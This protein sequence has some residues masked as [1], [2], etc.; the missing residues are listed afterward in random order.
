MN[1]LDSPDQTSRSSSEIQTDIQD[2][3]RRMDSTL[4]ELSN[5]LTPRSLMNT[6]MDW[7]DDKNAG[8]AGRAG[9]EKTYR[10]ICT[11]IKKNPAPSLLIG[12]GLT[13][14]F[15]KSDEEN[16]S[17]KHVRNRVYPASGN[18]DEAA[19]GHGGSTGDG[20]GGFIE[21]V[22]EKAGDAKDSIAEMVEGARHKAEDLTGG[23][24]QLG[25]RAKEAYESGKD[26]MRQQYDHGMQT[27]R[28]AVDDYPLAVGA[29][30]LA[31]GALAGVVLPASRREDRMLGQKSDELVKDVK[32]KG[33]DLLDRGK[34][35][36]G[37]LGQHLAAE[38]ESHGIT[39]ETV[40]DKLADI[41]RKTGD[42]VRDTIEGAGAAVVDPL[43]QQEPTAPGYGNLPRSA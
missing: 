29:A 31:L 30:F 36:A 5:R 1:H 42:V 34:E 8:A 13:W 4:D 41:T 23:A 17:T 40:G 39:A 11:Q 32:E 9:M 19:L 33:Q 7:W 37:E 12:A 14:L 18:M 28:T 16:G 3:R 10:V 15:L 25:H 2:T 21:K 24:G 26:T 22:K 35:K 20:E 27:L 6:A 43:E 38:A